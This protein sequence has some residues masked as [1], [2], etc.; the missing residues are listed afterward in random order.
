MGG[1]LSRTSPSP[2]A[3]VRGYFAAA[4]GFC[5]PVFFSGFALDSLFLPSALP[6]ESPLEGASEEPSLDGESPEEPD[7]VSADAAFSR[8]RLRV[9]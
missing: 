9:P 5:S 6:S 2:P 1:A 7:D 8:W 4:T 3:G